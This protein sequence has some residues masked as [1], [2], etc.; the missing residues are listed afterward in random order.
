[1]SEN[2]I[3][4]VP[5]SDACALR[6]RA[7]AIADANTASME[8]NSSGGVALPAEGRALA[9]FEASP[10]ALTT[11]NFRWRRTKSTVSAVCRAVAINS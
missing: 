4:T 10:S 3:V 7:R 5:S 8:P 1:M 2:K 9:P 6:S 11:C